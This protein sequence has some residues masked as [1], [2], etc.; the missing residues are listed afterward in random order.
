MPYYQTQNEFGQFRPT[1]RPR[2]QF[3]MNLRDLFP[4][5]TTEHLSF[6]AVKWGV[7]QTQ[8]SQQQS[9]QSLQPELSNTQQQQQQSQLTYQNLMD[10]SSST[11]SMPTNLNTASAYAPFPVSTADSSTEPTNTTPNP[12]DLT[13]SF[14]PSATGG[15]YDAF[16]FHSE[17]DTLLADS[18]AAYTGHTGMSLGFDTD[19]DWNDG[20]G[21]DLFDGF[22]F[23]GWGG[24]GGVGGVY[25]DS[26]PSGMGDGDGGMEGLERVGEVGEGLR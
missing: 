11:T 15:A 1:Q 9:R 14:Q 10:S 18:T 5:D 25:A 19:H 6:R 21:P 2:P 12:A 26:G 23:R 7:N 16:G 4:E 8:P 24:G 20:W 17:M 22:W 3:D 13:T